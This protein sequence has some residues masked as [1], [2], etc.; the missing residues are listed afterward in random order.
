[1][2]QCKE[3]C[4]NIEKNDYTENHSVTLFQL[5]VIDISFV[6]GGHF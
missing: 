5:R 6:V 1:M 3:R 4:L 2:P